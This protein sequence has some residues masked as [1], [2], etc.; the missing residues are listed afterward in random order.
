MRRNR[1]PHWRGLLRED[2]LFSQKVRDNLMTR[3]DLE[4]TIEGGNGGVYA[5]V[6]RDSG[7]FDEIGNYARPIYEQVMFAQDVLTLVNREIHHNGAWVAFFTNPA[8][9]A[10]ILNTETDFKRFG[11]IFIDGDGDPQFTVDWAEGEGDDFDFSDVLKSG[12]EAW[13][14]KLEGAWAQWHHLMR[15]VIDPAE[16]QTFKKAQGQRASSI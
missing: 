10:S 16:G 4:A 8:P 13:G 11:F 7:S 2:V 9:P 1:N 3:F 5:Y 15:D 14:H 6:M 12:L